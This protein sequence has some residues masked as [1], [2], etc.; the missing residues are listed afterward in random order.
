MSL[1]DSYVNIDFGNG[2]WWYGY[3][4]GFRVEFVVYFGFYGWWFVI[5]RCLL[6][7][8]KWC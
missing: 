7:I 3:G 5:W 1:I 2:L 4:Y 8:V 6:L